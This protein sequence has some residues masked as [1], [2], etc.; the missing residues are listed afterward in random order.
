VNLRK[1]HSHLLH[2]LNGDARISIHQP[3]NKSL[4][5]NASNSQ[6]FNVGAPASDSSYSQSAQVSE[7]TN[8]KIR[9]LTVD[10]S[11]RETMKDAAKCDK[12]CELQNSVNQ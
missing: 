5:A 3:R 12:H 7:L 4:P 10:S 8:K 11:A 1:D 2:T 6:F 9:P